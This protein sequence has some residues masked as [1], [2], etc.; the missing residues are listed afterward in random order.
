MV[1]KDHPFVFFY[2]CNKEAQ[3]IKGCKNKALFTVHKL[4][5]LSTIVVLTSQA[6][7]LL[8]KSLKCQFSNLS[9]PI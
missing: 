5:D 1:L 2:V 3:L 8:N 7:K 4:F 9:F 6:Q